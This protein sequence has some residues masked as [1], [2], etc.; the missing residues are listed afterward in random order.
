LEEKKIYY[1]GKQMDQRVILISTT[2]QSDSNKIFKNLKH[3]D[4]ENDV[5]D[6]YSDI[7]LT[8]KMNEVK[9]I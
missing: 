1:N 3:L 7:L 6:S 9:T 8:D 2:A 4:W 5:I